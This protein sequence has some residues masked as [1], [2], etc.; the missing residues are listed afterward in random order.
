LFI[1]KKSNKTL[2]KEELKKSPA[3]AQIY[4][5]QFYISNKFYTY[6]LTFIDIFGTTICSFSKIFSTREAI[7]NILPQGNLYIS[8]LNII[9]VYIILYK[10]LLLLLFRKEVNKLYIY[11]TIFM[12]LYF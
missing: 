11:K 1:R 10:T 4:L 12:V 5:D 2:H 7:V 6:Y 3:L 9:S 8:F